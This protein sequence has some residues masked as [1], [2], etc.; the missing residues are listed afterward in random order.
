[1]E[2]G[3]SEQFVEVGDMVLL[4]EIVQ[5]GTQDLFVQLEALRNKRVNLS[6]FDA[7]RDSVN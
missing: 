1:V 5:E 3:F 6:V 2:D 4:L 7:P